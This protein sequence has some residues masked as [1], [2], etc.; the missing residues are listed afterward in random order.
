MG[1]LTNSYFYK[2]F[3]RY[4]GRVLFRQSLLMLAGLADQQ[5]AWADPHHR[6]RE[7]NEL[8][9]LA[10]LAQEASSPD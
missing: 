9:G 2:G 4:R 1:L 6:E 5:F 8:V 10:K 3:D 7:W